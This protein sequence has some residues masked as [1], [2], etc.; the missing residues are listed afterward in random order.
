MARLGTLHTKIMDSDSQEDATSVRSTNQS[1]AEKTRKPP[2]TPFRQQRLWAWHPILTPLSALPLLFGIAL[3]F[4]PLGALQLHAS[5]SVQELS[6]DYS[7]CSELALSDRYTEVPAE[8]VS[9]HF[10]GGKEPAV[11]PL[12]KVVDL[13]KERQE[14]R[15]RTAQLHEF[16]TSHSDGD[17]DD[18]DD[19]NDNDNNNS[20]NTYNGHNGTRPHNRTFNRT[21]RFFIPANTACELVLDIPTD[22]G[23]PV[24]LLYKLTNFYQNHRR[25]VASFS[26][27]QLNG[28]APTAEELRE[29]GK[30]KPLIAD[31]DGKPYYPC[32]LI[33]NSM[34]NDTFA[35]QL[36]QV[37]VEGSSTEGYNVTAVNSTA[38]DNSASGNS[39]ADGLRRRQPWR[40]QA[41][42]TMNA[43]GITWPA[44]QHRFKRTSYTASQVVPPPNWA[45]IFPHGYTDD[46]LPDLSVFEPFQVWMRT[47]A[48]PTFTKLARRNDRD[49]L[50]QGTYS[51]RIGLNFPVLPYNGTKS[52]VLS[53][54]SVLGGRNAFLG[55]AYIVVA[56]VCFLAGV[57]FAIKQGVKPRRVGD[58]RYLSW[59]NGADGGGIRSGRTSSGLRRR[60]AI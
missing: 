34:F 4:A 11:K 18:D 43:T 7:Q 59:N 57:G 52:V 17:E 16:E 12:W 53:T 21:G 37:R 28:K 2:N 38:S 19:D 56:A 49:T 55:M 15:N 27:D 32:G 24:Y 36:G 60:R 29:N 45:G 54:S 48:F 5:N 33:A 42:Y 22:M 14:H 30:C 23:S 13:A 46:N 50:E 8:L 35:G 26:E 44:D 41:G 20:N 6:V 40:R 25:Y 3:V 47:S 1:T 51:L 10:K 39:T 31:S 58:V 9:Y